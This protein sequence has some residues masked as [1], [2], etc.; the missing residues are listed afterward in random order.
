ML[1]SLS[2]CIYSLIFFVEPHLYIYFMHCWDLDVRINYSIE[3]NTE[4]Q[5]FLAFV[6]NVFQKRMMW[7][8]VISIEMCKGIIVSML[9]CKIDLSS[10]V[11]IEF[12]STHKYS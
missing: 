1:E 11:F 12:Q 7:E 5:Y 3:I 8:I 9:E 2:I 6:L 4:Q 10:N